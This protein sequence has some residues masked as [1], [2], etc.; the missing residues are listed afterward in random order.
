VARRPVANPEQTRSAAFC[1]SAQTAADG[2]IAL[3]KT[4]GDLIR[5]HEIHHQANRVVRVVTH[6]DNGEAHA[7]LLFEGLIEIENQKSGIVWTPANDL[8]ALFPLAV[9]TK[10]ECVFQVSAPRETSYV[11]HR[12]YHVAK[13]VKTRLGVCEY[14][15]FEIEERGWNASDRYG[16]MYLGTRIYA[17]DLKFVVDFKVGKHGKVTADHTLAPLSELF[18]AVAT[19]RKGGKS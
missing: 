10:L 3:T 4:G 12:E 11:T 2:F 8:N 18:A 9:G 17:P 13:K 16:P 1:P 14:A 6:F 19:L 15:A 5:V 7:R